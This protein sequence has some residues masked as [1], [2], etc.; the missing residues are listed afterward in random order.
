MS[1]SCARRRPLSLNTRVMLFVAMAISLSLLVIG[2]LVQSAVEHHFAQQDAGELIV[3]THA[4]KSALQQSHDDDLAPK[5]TLAQAVSGHHGVYFQVWDEAGH[6]IYGPATPEALQQAKRHLSVEQTRADNLYRLPVDGKIYRA[7]IVQAQINATQYRILTAID[8]DFH[9]LFLKRFGHTLWIIMLLAGAVT[10]LAAWYGVHQGHK[11][12]RRL[13][14]TIRGIQADQL[15]LRLDPNTVPAELSTLVASFN[16]MISRLEDSFNHLSRFS[17]DIAHELRTPLTNMMTQTQVGLSKS[18]GLD[19]Y[20]ELLY[21]N[22]EEQERLTK[23]VNDMLWLAK[24]DN[25]LLKPAWESLDLLQEASATIDFFDALAEENKIRLQLDGSPTKVTGDRAMLRRTLSN[26]LSN[27]LRYTATGG[28]IRIA[29]GTMANGMGYLSVE[30]PGPEIP[31]EHLPKLFERFYR[32]D[33]ARQHQHEGAG[34]GLS[35]VKSIVE[36]HGGTIEVSSTNGTTCFVIQLPQGR[37]GT[38]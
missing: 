33:P 2:H 17:A 12:L 18:R 37:I 36:A 26:L 34:L 7:T 13:S 25:D 11:P 19:E 38:A 5:S 30:N 1:V 8:M 14:N 6:L 10:L 9:L 24:S 4:V 22:L 21:S 16:R 15:H 29:I 3:I 32:A 35:I 28:S 23:M 31:T 27:A 20:R